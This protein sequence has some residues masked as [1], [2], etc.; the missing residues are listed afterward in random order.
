ML[1]NSWDAQIQVAERLWPGEDHS[2]ITKFREALEGQTKVDI[3]TGEDAKLKGTRQEFEETIGN[4]IDAD[5]LLQELPKWDERG[6]NFLKAGTGNWNNH[7][8]L[9]LLGLQLSKR[10]DAVDVLELGS[11]EG[12]TPLLRKYCEDQK[13]TFLSYDNNHEWC[14]KTGANFALEW[15][16]LITIL[17][18]KHYGLIFI[19][20][21]PGERR[22]LDAIAL[23]NAADVLVLHDTEEGGAGNYMWDKAWPHFKYRLNYNKTGGG[24]G[25]SLVSNKI[26]VNRFRG[27]SLGPYTFDND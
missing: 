18:K 4:A 12:S 5:Y 26:D 15:D 20:H 13:L 16:T 23:A 9:I 25:A 7:L 8:P 3:V 17:A 2:F 19:D 27:L 6:N 21:A 14:L 10:G 24:A 22:H 1:R 11:G